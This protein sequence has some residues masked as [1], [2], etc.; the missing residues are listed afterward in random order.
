MKL[1]MHLY[2]RNRNNHVAPTKLTLKFL[3]QIVNQVEKYQTL[4]SLI[5]NFDQIP[6]KYVQVSL[7]IMAKHGE[8]NIP[9]AGAN[10]KRSITATFPITFDNKCL[11]MQ[12]IYKAK[13][14]LSGRFFTKRK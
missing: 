4:P 10:N 14:G 3:H 1:L 13:S 2:V 7:M 12:L 5:I 9:I 8:T 11:P 6:S